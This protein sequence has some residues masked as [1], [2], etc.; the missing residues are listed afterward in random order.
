MGVIGPLL[1]SAGFTYKAPTAVTS[2]VRAGHLMKVAMVMAVAIASLDPA[3]RP[4]MT[5]PPLLPWRL[6]LASASPRRRQLLQ[7]LDLPVEITQRGCG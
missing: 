7:G 6:I 4:Y 5:A 3:Y 2:I 1:L